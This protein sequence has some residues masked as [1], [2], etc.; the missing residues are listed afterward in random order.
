MGRHHLLVL[1]VVVGA[2]CLP[3]EVPVDFYISTSCDA[4]TAKAIRAGAELWNSSSCVE[5]TRYQGVNDD[6]IFTLDDLQDDRLTVYCVKDESEGDVQ[7]ILPP[8]VVGYSVGDILLPMNRITALV[9]KMFKKPPSAVP[10][11]YFSIVRGISAHELGHRLGFA[12]QDY[13]AVPSI[14]RKTV[15]DPYN[16][17]VPSL[18]DIY[19]S[20]K[21]DGL[22]DRI[23]C[24]PRDQCPTAPKF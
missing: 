20:S 9:Q 10:E 5:V 11:Q 23:Q 15:I 17:L 7:D 16:M 1:T 2:G 13:E 22:C 8:I 3:S 19:G 12:H 24:P 6:G 14:M 21:Q 4:A 18:L